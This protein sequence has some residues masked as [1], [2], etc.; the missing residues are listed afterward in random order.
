MF[1]VVYWWKHEVTI[2]SLKSAFFS[3][4]QIQIYQ[5]GMW[6]LKESEIYYK[7]KSPPTQN[8]NT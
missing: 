5:E 1:W 6:E 3:Q 7:D 4:G 8:N 2:F